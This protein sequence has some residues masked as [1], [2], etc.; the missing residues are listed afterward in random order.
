MCGIIGIL[1]TRGRPIDP[2]A[3]RAMAAS[4]RHRGPDDEGF[5][6]FSLR[7][8]TGAAWPSGSQAPSGEFEGGFGFQRLSILDL[9][10]NGHQPMASSDGRVIL[11][12][13]GEIYNAFDLKPEL[14]QRGC[15]F[16]SRSDTEV[17]LHLYREFGIEEALRR[18]NGMFAFLLADLDRREIHAVRDR[19]GIKPLYWYQKDG[20]HLLASEVKAFLCHPQFRATLDPRALDEHLMFRY[21][22]GEGF[23]LEGIRQLRPGYRAVLRPDGVEEIRYWD[24]PDPDPGA[25]PD[26]EALI[27]Q[28]ES[29]LQRS[30]Q[31]Q[32][33]SDVKVGCQL[34]GG[35]DSSLVNLFATRAERSSIDAFSIIFDDPRFSEEPWID[36][37]VEKAGVR[38]HRFLLKSS[39]FLETM[40][41]A[42]WHLDEPLVHPNSIGIW[43]L[44][45]LARPFVTVLL[46][47]EGADEVFGGYERFV[48]F[49]LRPKLGPMLPLLSRLPKIG[50]RFAERFGRN[51]HTDDITWYLMQTASLSLTAAATLRP[52]GK[53]GDIVEQRAA[54]FRTGH[55]SDLARCLR[56]ELSTYLVSLLIRQDKMTMAH[57]LEN[58]VPFL[59]HELVEFVRGLTPNRLVGGGW[60]RFGIRDGNT[61][62]PLKALASRH[63]GHEFTYRAKQGF[64]IPLVEFLGTPGFRQKMQ[65]ELLPGIASRGVLDFAT[66]ERAWSAFLAG[67]ARSVDLLWNAASFESWARQFLDGARRVPVETADRPFARLA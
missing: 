25:S 66:V 45:K 39:A 35:V 67:D 7:K 29:R 36:I 9:S 24:I 28:L 42:T 63:F 2:P 13:N 38:G 44:S 1:D 41:D 14:E 6:L 60:S 32:L 48:H 16:R 18:V 12:F 21:C 8:G 19:L 3:L 27:D 40:D 37:A 54:R 61:K 34:S 65:E 26:P 22:A 30:V 51:R 20:V 55:G 10:P 53:F 11:I 57:S 62:I 59:D 47:G 23:L 64:S 56:Y 52:E 46:S 50:P 49:R 4:I 17:L 58:R 31:V 43:H 15:V 33:L 5:H